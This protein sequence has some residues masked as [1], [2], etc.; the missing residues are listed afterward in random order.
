MDPGQWMSRKSENLQVLLFILQNKYHGWKIPNRQIYVR[1]Y[2]SQIVWYINYIINDKNNISSKIICRHIWPT[3]FHF[4]V[5]PIN[6][7]I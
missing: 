3:G 7:L 5:T 1:I 4:S 2:I 6:P